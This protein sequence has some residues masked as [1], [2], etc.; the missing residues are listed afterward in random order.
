MSRS[1]PGETRRSSPASSST[2][3]SLTQRSAARIVAAAEASLQRLGTDRIDLYQQHQ[4]DPQTPIDEILEA[5]DRLVSAGKVREVGCCNFV[6]EQIDA[7]A[8]TA[9]RRSLAPYRSNQVQYSLLERPP[10]D[11]LRA[12]TN[13]GMSILA[14]F[15]L[16]NGLLSGKYRRGQTPPSDWRLGADA[17]VSTMLRQGLL[18][19]RPPLSEE[20]LATVEELEN[21][22]RE[23]GHSL[24]ELAIS[25]LAAQPVVTAVIPGVS[26][27][28]AG[29]GQRIRSRLGPVLGGAIRSGD[30]PRTRGQCRRGMNSVTSGQGR[31]PPTTNAPDHSLTVRTASERGADRRAIRRC[32]RATREEDRHEICRVCRWDALRTPLNTPVN[33]SL[34]AGQSAFDGATLIMWLAKMSASSRPAPEHGRRGQRDGTEG[35]SA[36]G[37]QAL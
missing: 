3:A 2:P 19:R 12:V 4:P 20:R 33:R 36:A 29:P 13:R 1:A 9:D 23:R 30:D 37:P 8:E 16:A 31:L 10:D 21:F 15:P 27:R 24:L 14:Y 32:L 11:V 26:P 6:A 25:W 35:P 22:A 5:L 7:A 17:P 18:A 34:N 28:G